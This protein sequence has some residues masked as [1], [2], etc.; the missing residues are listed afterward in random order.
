M[1]S[2][3]IFKS[4]SYLGIANLITIPTTAVATILLAKY[5]I[6]EQLGIYMAGEAFVGIF[7]FFFTM[8]FKNSILKFASENKESFEKGLGAA[9]G[10]AIVVRAL[11]TIP[12]ALVIFL[13]GKYFNQ[14]IMMVKVILAFILVE[15]F[16][17]FTNIFG[18]A[19]KALD[20]FKLVASL[21]IFDKFLK[22]AIILIVFNYIGGLEQYLWALVIVNLIKFLI[23][24]FSTVSLCKPSIDYK[25][26]IPM[27]KESFLYGIFDYMENAQS[28]VDRLMINFILGPSAVAFYSIPSKLN[29]LIRVLPISIRQVFLP[30]LHK[31]S[32]DPKKFKGLI[33]KLQILLAI[34][35]IPVALGIYFCSE[36]ILSFCFNEQYQTAIELAP[37]FAFIALIWFMNAQPVM[38][39]ASKGDHKGR[40]A[41][42]LLCVITNIG[43]NFIFIP[44]FGI[45]GAIYATISANLLKFIALQVRYKV[46]FS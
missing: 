22:L 23:S 21:N 4:F 5:L 25:N 11:I 38:L 27:I 14:D 3:N 34:T 33:K 35:G 20:Q 8:G 6:P 36:Y 26:I 31:H 44:K 12:I 7:S 17:S 42:Q 13:L 41:I 24:F 40:N 46:K 19:R 43:L 45:Q 15:L 30:Q 37:L 10:N 18:I 1:K 39:L 28:K 29:R 2:K 32:D 9:L 16:R